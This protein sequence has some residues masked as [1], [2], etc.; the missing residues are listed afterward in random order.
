VAESHREA[1][2][3]FLMSPSLTQFLVK[4]PEWPTPLL[5]KDVLLFTHMRPLEGI[6]LAQLGRDG[7]Y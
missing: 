5:P 3:N 4:H 7:N 1:L 6:F 2:D